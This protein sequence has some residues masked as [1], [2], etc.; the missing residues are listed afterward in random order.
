[1]SLYKVWCDNNNNKVKYKHDVEL[2]MTFTLTP[3]SNGTYFPKLDY[4]DFIYVDIVKT[5]YNE[6]EDAWLIR[7]E[8][9]HK[10]KCCWLFV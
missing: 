3:R 8:Y 9:G 2:A 7:D 10:S 4:Q 5:V 6:W 1:M